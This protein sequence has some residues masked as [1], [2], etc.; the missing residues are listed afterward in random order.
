MTSIRRA[1]ATLGAAALLAAPVSMLGAAPASAGPE[2]DREF[3]IAGAEV[4]FEVEK[5]DGRF[6]VDVDLDD[7]RPGTKWR[8]VLRHDGRTFHNKVHRADGDG[9]VDVDKKRRNTRGADVFKLTVKRIGGPKKVR[10]IR[11]R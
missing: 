1:T 9:E 11:M 8:V 7:A 5:D 3:R 2:K 10:T 4:D 6:E